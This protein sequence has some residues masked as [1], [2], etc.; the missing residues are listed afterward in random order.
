MA[1]ATARDLVRV[2][3]TARPLFLQLA[4]TTGC[5]CING[6]G[7]TMKRV[8]GRKTDQPAVVF[9]VNRKLS[10]RNLPVQSRIPQQINIP[11][12]YTEDGVLE[13]ITDVQAVRFQA[14][15]F[16]TRERPCPSAFSIGHID[17]TAGTLGCLVKDKLTPDVPVILSNNHVLANSNQATEGDPIVQPGP[18]DG[19]TAPDDVIATLTRWKDIDFSGASNRIDAAIATPLD[20]WADFVVQNIEDVGATIP[21]ATRDITVDDLGAFVRKSGRTTE[22]TTGYVDAVNVTV[23]VKY[24]LGE[25]ATFVDQI[26][27][28]QVLVEEDIAAGGDSGSAVL[29]NENNLIGLLFAGSERDD[30][31]GEPAT[32]IVNPIKHVFTLLELETWTP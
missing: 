8:A 6:F 4:A 25:K 19:G 31:A 22:H 15:E 21:T 17:I 2:M 12:E 32:A 27:I 24:G 30:G 20:P 7:I 10:L 3:R 11:W 16:K 26:V 18:H 5:D 13:V 9:Y 29:D 28:E 1:R 23:Q 14:F